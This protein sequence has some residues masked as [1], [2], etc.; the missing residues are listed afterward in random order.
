LSDVF[1]ALALPL[2]VLVVLVLLVI[3]LV[4]FAVFLISFLRKSPAYRG[5]T[6]PVSV[7]VCA[8]DELEN[9]K[10]LIPLLLSQDY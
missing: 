3:Q 8:H 6:L 4:Y 2:I 1:N 10:V 5:K 7:V 9:L